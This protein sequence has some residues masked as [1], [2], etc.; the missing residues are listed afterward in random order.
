MWSSK[1]P[2][3]LSGI[4][5]EEKYRLSQ[6]Y[7]KA[8]KKLSFITSSFSLVAMLILLLTGSFSMVLGLAEKIS[9]NPV[10]ATLIFF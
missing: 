8:K 6:Y 3:E 10:W 9:Y 1:L 7:D 2:P 4:Y 5:D